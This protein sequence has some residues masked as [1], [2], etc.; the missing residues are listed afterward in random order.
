VVVLAETLLTFVTG[1]NSLCSFFNH[2]TSDNMPNNIKDK[3]CVLTGAAS[4]IG[5][6]CAKLL[7]ADGAKLALVDVN[8]EGLER[9]A[10]E[11]DS[12]DV[13]ILVLSV[14]SESDMNSM[15]EQVLGR[16]GRIDCLIACAGILRVGGALKTIADTPLDDW[17]AV[18]ETNLT[19]TFLS[20]R[21]VLP[22]MIAQRE[23]DIVNVSST[24]GRQGRPFDGPYSASKFGIVGLSESLAEEVASYGVRVQTIL[25]DAVET[26]LWDQN[27]PAALKP[28]N[29]L[30]PQRVAEFILYLVQLPRDTYLANPVIAPMKTRR[31]KR[32]KT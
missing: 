17:H 32:E 15:A 13:L 5:Q 20:N 28:V 22:A 31:K 18:L 8:R 10:G 30:P 24:S 23:G 4:G 27:G 1:Q 9:L 19:G 6:A 21:A 3:V 29:V 14:R 16:F 12:S 7:A 11:L 26:P 25:P 2:K